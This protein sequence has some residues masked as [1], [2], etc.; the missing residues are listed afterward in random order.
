MNIFKHIPRW[1]FIATGIACVVVI[2]TFWLAGIWAPV[3]FGT[4]SVI[5]SDGSTISVEVAESSAEQ[6]RGLMDRKSMDPES[7]MLF[8]LKKPG[9]YTF[10]M[11]DT[12]IDLDFIWLL[13]GQVV[14][15]R[16]NVP[17]GNDLPGDQVSRVQPQTT[18]DAVLEVPAGFV[19]R[20]QIEV[21][22]K[23]TYRIP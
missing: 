17:A 13:D 6:R 7:G 3:K 1:Q 14:D 12:Y 19:D 22:D 11:K 4:G 23:F 21:G 5:L 18:I 15:L 2:V 9:I 8:L 20:H 10:W 16:T